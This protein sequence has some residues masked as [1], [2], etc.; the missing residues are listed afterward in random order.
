LTFLESKID[1][2]PHIQL[3]FLPKD[4]ITLFSKER[5]GSFH[6]QDDSFFVKKKRDSEVGLPQQ[7]IKL[8]NEKFLSRSQNFYSSDIEKNT[9]RAI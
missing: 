9:F 4:P 1:Y 2:F 5:N 6:F 7:K 8:S 3:P